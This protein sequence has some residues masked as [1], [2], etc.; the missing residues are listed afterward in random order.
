[1]NFLPHRARDRLA[2]GRFPHARGPDEAEDRPLH[3]VLQL[4]HGEV[5]QDPLLD[6]LEVVVVLVEDLLRLGDADVV[7][8]LLLPGKLHHPVQVGA[9]DGRLGRIGMHPLQ[10]AELFLGLLQHLLGHPGPFDLPLQVVDFLGLPVDVAQLLLD[11]L[12]LFP[13]EIFPLAFRHLLLRLV[14][15]LRLHLGKLQLPREQVVDERQARDGVLL[16]EHRLGLLDLQAQVRGDEVG[17]HAGVVDVLGHHQDLDRHVLQ[18]KDLLD[19]LAGGA[20]Q[21]L[22]LEGPL[23]QRGLHEPVDPDAHGGLRLD[24]LEDLP[25][26]DALDEDLQPAVGQLQHPH[27]H[28][29]RAGAVEVRFLRVLHR[30]ILLGG[31]ED[32]PVPRQ[33]LVDRGDRTFPAHEQRQGHVREYDDVAHRQQREH[34]GDLRPAFLLLRLDFGRGIL[35]LRSLHGRFRDLRQVRLL[36]LVAHVVVPPSV[37]PVIP[38]SR[39][40]A[41]PGRAVPR[42]WGS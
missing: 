11:R 20:H 23:L 39:G 29:H 41:A 15:D 31:E 35:R 24:E 19:L 30:R 8:R 22:H 33:R 17:Q 7:L 42:S 26:Q 18:R 12:H 25:L 34:L 1:M 6:L 3:L 14:L 5:L 9:H 13:E 28:R 4:A 21:R 10:A 38:R 27:D 32:V 16:L 37:L 2:Q 36:R 40:S